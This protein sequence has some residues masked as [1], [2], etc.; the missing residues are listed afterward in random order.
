MLWTDGDFITANELIALDAEVG[1]VST[2]EVITLLGPTGIIHKAIE[3]AGDSLMK[4]AQ[5][6]GGAVYNG[7][8]SSNHYAAVMNV[9]LPA[10]NRAKYLPVQIV[11]T[12]LYQNTTSELKKWAQYWALQVFYRDASN[13][14]LNDRYRIKAASYNDMLH[15]RYWEA[16]RAK[17]IP[18]VNTPLPCPG[19]I[20]DINPGSWGNNNLSTVANSAGSLVGSVSAV[21]TWFNGTVNT[22][23]ESNPSACATVTISS[24]QVLSV[25]IAGLNPP[26]GQ[27]PPSTMTLSSITYGTT[28]GWNLYVSV[29]GGPLV[30]QNSSPIPVATQSY[31]LLGNPLTSGPVAGTGQWPDQYA[32]LANVIQRG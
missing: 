30:L 11:V 29:N 21:V 4:Y 9:G 22:N 16:V 8:V 15:K 17:G 12:G 23:N 7:A 20:Y 6:F 32:S 31:T 2:A 27:Q 25:S 19:A 13:R 14:T 24:G 10:V 5:Q 18:L 1:D 28:T 26:M 3:E